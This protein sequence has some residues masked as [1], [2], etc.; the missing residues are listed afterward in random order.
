MAY[1]TYVKFLRGTP[2]TYQNLACKDKDTLYFISTPNSNEFQLYFGE[3]RLAGSEGGSST[4]MTLRDLKDIAIKEH[5]FD[6]S[7]L[8]YNPSKKVW[9]DIEIN[10]VLQLIA[11]EMI[12]AT[13]THDG[14]QGLVPVPKKGQHRFFLRGD[15]QWA[16]PIS[17]ADRALIQQ[18]QTNIQQLQNS[19][20]WQD[21]SKG[22]N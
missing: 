2:T 19:V 8:A 3:K 10:D 22:E 13:S 6:R 20:E 4:L 7:F 16:E 9:E 17:Q 1:N 11:Q 21:F 14:K 15:G 5:I 12:G 18:M